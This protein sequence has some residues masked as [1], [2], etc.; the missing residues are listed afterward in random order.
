MDNL[1]QIFWKWIGNSHLTL[2][3]DCYSLLNFSCVFLFKSP[4]HKLRIESH[5][6]AIVKAIAVTSYCAFTRKDIAICHDLFCYPDIIERSDYQMYPL[7]VCS[8]IIVSWN[9]ARI[10]S[11]EQPVFMGEIL[12]NSEI[13]N[14]KK[15]WILRFWVTKS[16]GKKG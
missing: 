6:R 14:L 1:P 10:R 4:I 3:L 5:K 8:D 15:K 7:K 12:P 13:T 11:L 9:S 16:E 2:S